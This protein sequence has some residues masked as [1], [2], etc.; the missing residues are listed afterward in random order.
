[1]P[2]HCITSVPSFILG[3]NIR[4]GL[5]ARSCAFVSGYTETLLTNEQAKQLSFGGSRDRKKRKGQKFPILD[6]SP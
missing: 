6:K 5:L 4:G 2:L 1:M 3:C